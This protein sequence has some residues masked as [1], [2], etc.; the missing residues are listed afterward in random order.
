MVKFSDVEEEKLLKQTVKL[1]KFSRRE[2]RLKFAFRPVN[3]DG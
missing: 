2:T 3:Q 1:L